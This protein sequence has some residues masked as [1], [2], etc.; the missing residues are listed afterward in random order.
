MKLKKSR[1]KLSALLK[2]GW[3]R[4]DF[5]GFFT[6]F[7]RFFYVFFSYEIIGVRLLPVLLLVFC[8]INLSSL[9]TLSRYTR[10]TQITAVVE[11]PRTVFNSLESVLRW[12]LSWLRK[13]HGFRK[14]A[15]K[16]RSKFN[17]EKSIRGGGCRPRT[18]R[19]S[20]HDC[21]HWVVPGK[22]AARW[23]TGEILWL[24]TSVLEDFFP[25]FLLRSH[26]RVYTKTRYL[27]RDYLI[28]MNACCITTGY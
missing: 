22:T 26:V 11:G 1:Q 4:N 27:E 19:M 5:Y 24:R 13:T 10:Y 25:F 17:D 18:A 20:L 16:N 6:F 28:I 8:P 14:I 9:F 15:Q 23:E 2:R 7:L 21:H 3:D 12:L